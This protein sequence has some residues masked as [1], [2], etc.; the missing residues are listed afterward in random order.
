M[1]VYLKGDANVPISSPL[2]WHR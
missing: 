2:I 1:K